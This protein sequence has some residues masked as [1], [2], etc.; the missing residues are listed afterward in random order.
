M[1]PKVRLDICEKDPTLFKEAI[2]ASQDETGFAGAMIE[3]DYFCTLVLHHL[4]MSGDN[5]L[6]F[7]GG[8]C[9][10][11]VYADFYRL[12]EDLDF[13]IPMHSNVSRAARS[14]AFASAKVAIESIPDRYPAF[15]IE[16]L[17]GANE[18]KQYLAYLNYKSMYGKGKGII[19]IEVGL[20]ELLWDGPVQGAAKTILL[21]P[22]TKTALLQPINI[23]CISFRES[24]AEKF[25]AALTRREVAIR[26]FFDIA[27]AVQFLDFGY[28]DRDFL[29]MVNTKLAVPGNNAPDLS[30]TR[31]ADLKAQLESQLKPVLRP[32]DFATFDLDTTIEIVKNVART[33]GY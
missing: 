9:L 30:D 11:K 16:R 24:L 10:S 8:T 27:Y 28:L 32:K 12:S 3:K 29:T 6:V 18:S 4:V 14:D 22:I 13:I 20:R 5:G 26:D 21:D 1:K 15:Q 17:Q 19:K 25:R 7:K 33:V 23:P 2:D 31:L